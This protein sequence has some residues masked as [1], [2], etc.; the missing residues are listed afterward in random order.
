MKKILFL[1]LFLFSSC[2]YEAIYIDKNNSNFK[3]QEIIFEG[4]KNLNDKISS[5]LS[6]KEINS[7]K[8]LD[9]I[10]IKSDKNKIEA[11]KN[12]KGHVTSYKMYININLIIIDPSNKIKT[13]K[14]F[15]ND[16]LY[17][18]DNDK[19]KTTEYQKEIENNLINQIIRDINVFLKL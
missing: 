17:N 15:K 2:G 8:T 5:R 16:F 3:F 9:K 10:L 11:S 7:D 1:I 14:I 6:F 13:N 4:D 19:F 18:V 12:S